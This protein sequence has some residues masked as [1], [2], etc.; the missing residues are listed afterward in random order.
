[1]RLTGELERGIERG[2]VSGLIGWVDRVGCEGE[3]IGW[4][5][6]GRVGSI[7]LTECLV[8]GFISS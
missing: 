2:D 3:L 5:G 6:R 7:H 1:M 4:V 8:R